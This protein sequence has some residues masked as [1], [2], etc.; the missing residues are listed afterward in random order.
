MSRFKG[1]KAE[2]AARTTPPPAAA[3]SSSTTTRAKARE[4]KRAVVGYFSED[5]SRQLRM[6]AVEEGSTVQALVGEAIDLLLQARGKHTFG[7][8]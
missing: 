1:L 5:L 3:S 8:R 6:L 4:G 2:V 7:E